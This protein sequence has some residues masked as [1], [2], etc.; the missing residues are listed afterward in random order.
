MKK[1][2]VLLVSLLLSGGAFSGQVAN[3]EACDKYNRGKSSRALC[4]GVADFS[5]LTPSRIKTCYDS[6]KNEGVYKKC[7][8]EAATS[9]ISEEEIKECSRQTKIPVSAKNCLHAAAYSVSLTLADI[10][11]CGENNNL[12]NTF[13]ACLVNEAGDL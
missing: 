5:D 2:L 12:P 13:A 6:F 11:Y 4:Y 3:E 8:D 1:F 10:V 9:D 7:V